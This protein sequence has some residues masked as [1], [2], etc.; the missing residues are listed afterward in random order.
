MKKKIYLAGGMQNLTFEEAWEWR[1]AVEDA[2]NERSDNFVCFNIL[3]HHM[4]DEVEYCLSNLRRSDVVVVNF[5]DPKSLGTMAEIT[6]A[7]EH[8]IPIIGYI[9]K[10]DD[11]EMLHRWIR[12]MVKEV[13]TT[14]ND[15]IDTIM[16]YED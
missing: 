12:Y 11:N 14:F 8:R 9:S 3:K 6:L 10:P 1:K 16:D 15:L 4:K 5:N 2:V 7:Y 13:C